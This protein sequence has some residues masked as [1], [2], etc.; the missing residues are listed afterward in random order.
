MKVCEICLTKGHQEPRF[1]SW[2]PQHYMLFLCGYYSQSDSGLG[3][4]TSY[5]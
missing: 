1:Y 2:M 4:H 5:R 3:E